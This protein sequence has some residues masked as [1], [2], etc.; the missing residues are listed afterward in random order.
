MQ[1]EQLPQDQLLSKL[2]SFCQKLDNLTSEKMNLEYALNLREN[3]LS[4]IEIEIR[5]RLITLTQKLTE[6]QQERAQ[7]DYIL[8]AISL[9]TDDSEKKMLIAHAKLEQEVFKRTQELAEKNT[10]LQTEIRERQ[11]I[12]N[13]LR[14]AAT[15]FQASNEGIFI[16][17]AQYK[18]IKINPSYTNLTGYTEQESLGKTLD[19]LRSKRH[20]DDFYRKMW[21]AL[22]IVGYWSGEIWHQRKNSED[23]PSWL[24]MNA[25][26][27]D[28]NDV[29]YYIGIFTDNTYQKLSEERAYYLANFD[30]LTDLSNRILFQDRLQQVLKWAQ[31]DQ[32]WVALLLIDLDHFKAINE[33]FGHTSGD[34][35][36]R[37]TAK[38]LVSCLHDEKD[39]I[40][41][42]GGDEFVI[43]LSDLQPNQ[44]ALQ[45]ISDLADKILTNLQQLFILDGH[46]EQ[47]IFITASIGITIFPQ[48]GQTVAALLKN[49]D[50]ALYEAKELGR[51]NYQFFTNTMNVVAHR[52]LTLQNCLRRALER[53]EL[54]LY[55]QPQIDVYTQEV[56]GAEVLLRWDHPKYGMIAPS[57]FIPIAEDSGLIIPISEWILAKVCEQRQAFQQQG[58]KSIRIAVNLSARQFHYD[59]LIPNIISTLKKYDLSADWLELEITETIAMSGADKTINMLKALKN[60][61]ILLAIDDFGTGYSSLNYLKYFTVDTLKIDS[62]FIKD[63]TTT[64]GAALVV[65]IINM[66]HSLQMTIV[67]EGVETEEQLIFLHEHRCDIVQGYFF[68]R[69]LLPNVLANL[70]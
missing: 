25:V 11:R 27:N 70:L 47:E 28:Q 1:A 41:R 36:V 16:T 10:L 4:T 51:N 26:K 23:F 7:L 50:S 33:A 24:S 48:D 55:Y 8:K 2:Q 5:D 18:I 46:E 39:A 3:S 12:E 22:T 64:N 65:A 38:R 34:Q 45:V 31:R 63:I 54:L 35:L 44:Q 37:M 13:D 49:A 59:G 61:G 9:Y 53:D 29:I 66:A 20:H 21:Q 60:L 19:I 68:Y 57:E 14:L 56:V 58:L 67:A 62:S 17:D 32:H 42:L 6:L 52:R 15:V 69:P 30:A 43:L 40:A